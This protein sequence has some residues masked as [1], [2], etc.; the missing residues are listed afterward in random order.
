MSGGKFG[1]DKFEDKDAVDKFKAPG[2][3]TSASNGLLS[4]LN[5]KA[6]TSKELLPIL[7][8]LK[9]LMRSKSYT[10]IDDF[11]ILL[12]EKDASTLVKV[13]TLRVVG[14]VA[15]ALIMWEPARDLFVEQIPNYKTVMR[16]LL[17]I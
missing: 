17:A 15:G 5:L 7:T 4:G 3:G 6:E 16:G 13:G 9:N 10:E 11:L 14:A 12:M 2:V 1:N 8:Y